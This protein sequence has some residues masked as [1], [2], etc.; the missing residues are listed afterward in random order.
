MAS[1]KNWRPKLK[2]SNAVEMKTHQNL[3]SCALHTRKPHIQFNCRIF[4]LYTPNTIG[5]DR[6]WPPLTPPPNRFHFSP[7][8]LPKLA[9]TPDQFEAPTSS[10]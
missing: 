5:E 2:T 4:F 9:L 8:S 10:A 3:I 1:N 7:N 6:A